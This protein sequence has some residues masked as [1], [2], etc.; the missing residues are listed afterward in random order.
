V[1][2]CGHKYGY[3]NLDTPHQDRSRNTLILD[4]L[5]LGE[6]FQN[7]HHARATSPNFAVRWFEVDPAWLVISCLARLRVIQL[8]R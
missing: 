6:L 4:F 1:N 8:A 3:R 5:T 7:N 2:W